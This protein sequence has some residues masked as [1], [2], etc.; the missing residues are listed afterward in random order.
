M[1]EGCT[2][3]ALVCWGYEFGGAAQALC[4]RASKSSIE[5]RT[6]ANYFLCGKLLQFFLSEAGALGS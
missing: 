5:C 6:Q 1:P 3:E 2:I 4:T